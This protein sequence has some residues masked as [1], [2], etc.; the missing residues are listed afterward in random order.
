MKEGRRK[1]KDERYELN[2]LE[3][4]PSRTL[5]FR[6][7]RSNAAGVG[8]VVA[9]SNP[10][11]V[12]A[13]SEA[14]QTTGLRVGD[15]VRI[16]A[17][18]TTLHARCDAGSPVRA[19]LLR[20]DV[21]AIEGFV[22]GWVTVRDQA[23]GARGCLRRTA[24]ELGP[25]LPADPQKPGA[26]PKEMPAPGR[27]PLPPPRPSRPVRVSGYGHAGSLSFAASRSFDAIL[28]TSSGPVFGGG[29][30]V[31][32]QRG[33]LRNVFFG[34]DVTRFRDTGERVFVNN[35]EVFKLGIPTT[36]TVT[37]IEFTAGYRF[38]F[39]PRKPRVPPAK[40]PPPRKLEVGQTKPGTPDPQPGKPP[41]KPT[42]K[43]PPDASGGFRL[44]P[45]AGGGIGSVQYT[46]E[47]AFAAPGENID[48]RFTSYH[49]LGGV[50]IPIWRWI[51]V[52]VE[53]HYRWVPDALGVAGV[54]DAFNETN[55]GG[56]TFRVKFG[57]GF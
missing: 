16:E 25:T 50:E 38:V 31:A 3:R 22:D 44:V 1:K 23:S 37:P 15:R 30:Q 35:G 51:G 14:Q 12:L 33:F 32:F 8:L 56:A 42:A 46:E 18:S 55:L 2:L 17:E 39:G 48:D 41:A 6:W 19:K 24:L 27:R 57:V 20:R 11:S 26:S 54:S 4:V 34:V 7:C 47:S 28:D 21:V 13:A 29:G 36:I 9:L 5:L 53:G 40:P 43:A 49:A 52:A 10:T 45:Y